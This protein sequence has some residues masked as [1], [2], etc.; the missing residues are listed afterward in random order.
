M[1]RFLRSD[2]TPLSDKD[3]QDIINA[4]NIMKRASEAMATKYKIST[5]RVYQIWRE[6]HP[7]IDTRYVTSQ[8][9]RREMIQISDESGINNQDL[10]EFYK[11]EAERDKINVERYLSIM[12]KEP[13]QEEDL[14]LV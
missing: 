3:I 1:V 2:A 12:K 8:R 4:K 14:P 9:D 10:D 11:K 5:R 6:E 7:P 13:I